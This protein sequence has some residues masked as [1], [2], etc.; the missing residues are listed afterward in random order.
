MSLFGS[1]S[2][3][4]KNKYGD[5]RTAP[6]K[7]AVFPSPA[8]RKEL[9]SG[10]RSG[11]GGQ[12]RNALLPAL[13]SSASREAMMR[14]GVAS[15][16]LS[17][18]PASGDVM[19]L[20]ASS[21]MADLLMGLRTQASAG[22]QGVPSA[23]SSK[24]DILGGAA[25]GFVAGGPFGAIAGGLG[26][27]LNSRAK[28]QARSNSLKHIDRAIE[29]SSPERSAEIFR[30]VYPQAREVS[31]ASGAGQRRA[32]AIESAIT[33]SGLRGTGLGSLASVAAGVQPELAGLEEAIGMTRDI[34]QEQVSSVLG[35]PV[36][37]S[38]DPITNALEALAQGFLGYKAAGSRPTA[39]TRVPENTGFGSPPLLPGE[40]D[41]NYRP[42]MERAGS[43]I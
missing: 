42:P 35:T 10:L 37:S 34:Q 2:D 30:D 11:F 41:P 7:A 6:R 12:V 32:Q 3:W 22:L 39:A 24:A 38:K 8:L 23:G 26:G 16:L 21:D 43:N 5:P 27:A 18:I 29:F 20:L 25:Q 19:A 9:L 40:Y 4:Y 36:Q 28:T 31:M 14:G 13:S 33:L 17:D 1:D 15:S